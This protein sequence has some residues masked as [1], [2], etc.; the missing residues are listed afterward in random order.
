MTVGKIKKI[1]MYQMQFD[2]I[3]PEEQKLVADY[4]RQVITEEQ[5]FEIGAVQALKNY[6]EIG[7]SVSKKKN[8]RKRISKSL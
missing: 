8:K 1:S 6:I 4:G 3:T 5:Y 2:N 7:K